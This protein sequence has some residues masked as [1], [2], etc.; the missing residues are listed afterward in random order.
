MILLGAALV[1]D[2]NAQRLT[3]KP[4]TPFVATKAQEGT[5]TIFRIKSSTNKPVSVRPDGDLCLLTFTESPDVAGLSQAQLNARKDTRDWQQ[6]I[7]GRMRNS[8]YRV[9]E[10]FTV[11]GIRGMDFLGL[12]K[13]APGEKTTATY[14]AIIETPKGQTILTCATLEEGFESAVTQFRAI[15]DSIVPER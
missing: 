6:Y 2:A 12:K 13:T 9:G 4:P 1:G 14:L 5:P 7:V 15:R 10:A 3:V 8:D 11:T